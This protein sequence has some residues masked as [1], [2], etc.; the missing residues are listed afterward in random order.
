[1]TH[2]VV[3]GPQK[4]PAEEAPVPSC[5][6][7]DT[8][9][10]AGDPEGSR[11]HE[12]RTSRVNH[13]V[14]EDSA[15]THLHSFGRCLVR[16]RGRPSTVF[17]WRQDATQGLPFPSPGWTGRGRPALS[18]SL[19]KGASSGRPSGTSTF[20]LPAPRGRLVETPESCLLTVEAFAPS[21]PARC[22]AYRSREPGQTGQTRPAPAGTWPSRPEP[23]SRSGLGGAPRPHLAQDGGP[24]PGLRE[25]TSP[26]TGAQL[27]GP[28]RS[29]RPT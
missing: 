9:A 15:R 18:S 13:P 20:R 16:Y 28:R 3:T 22:R 10:G 26:G 8:A 2:P 12:S 23:R 11:G 4:P 25:A 6:A 27:Y 21:F 19:S 17:T 29:R 5:P 24:S 1:M 14:P 7:A